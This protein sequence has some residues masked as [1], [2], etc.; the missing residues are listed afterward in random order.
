[1]VNFTLII[2]MVLVSVLL[3]FAIGAND[4]T[5]STVIGVKRLSIKA[6][7][8]MGAIIAI[9]GAFIFAPKVCET[10]HNDITSLDIVQD[11]TIFSIFLAMAT[12]LILAS[13][14]GLP[15]SSTEAM[16]GSILG[17]T[18]ALGGKVNWGITGMGKVFIT[19]I[20]SP[21]LGLT[22][23]FLLMK[24]TNCVLTKK[25]NGLRALE[26][27]NE[28]FG[29]LLLGMVIITGLSRAGNDISNAIAPIV[30]LFQKED[31][32]IFYERLPMI[33][34]GAGLGLGLIVIG[35]RVLDTLGNEVVELTPE[36]AFVTEGAAAIIVLVAV[37]LGIPVSGTL[38]LVS[39][40]V[41]AGLGMNKPINLKTI[42]AIVLF[43]FLTPIIS[44]G[45]AIGFYYLLGLV[46]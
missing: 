44:G 22:G 30:P 36:S 6:A 13:V 23:S 16:V 1:M 28:I 37:N 26:T 14:F 21:L 17:L 8:I 5:F 35:R 27:S 3:A 34:G 25:V 15:I 4:E 45:G 41:G 29:V 24:L 2:M 19:W 33:L 38:T 11:R 40:F 20:T 10:L 39:S 31:S 42:R 46:F 32:S 7:V 12:S 9:I 43:V 18:F